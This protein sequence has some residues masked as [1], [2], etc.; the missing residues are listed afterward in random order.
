MELT[1]KKLEKG[2]EP[3]DLIS[4]CTE[5]DKFVSNPPLEC[6]G[7][8]AVLSAVVWNM[9]QRFVDFVNIGDSRIYKLTA[10]DEL[11]QISTDELK[12]VIMRKPNGKPE[13]TNGSAIVRAGLT[14]AFGVG[15][16]Q[17]NPQ[18]CEF[19]PGDTLFLA[20][21]GFYDCHSSFENDLR[22]IAH[23]LD[24]SEPTAKIFKF[25]QN[26]Q[27]DDA[28]LL[29]LRN[30]TFDTAAQNLTE[31]N[32]SELKGK[33]PKFRLCEIMN[34]RLEAEILQKN[35]NAALATLA[36][37]E[38]EHLLP[39]KTMLDALLQTMKTNNFTDGAVFGGIVRL[40]KET[41]K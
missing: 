11:H 15:T 4:I 27:N 37:M 31:S 34:E 24:L 26:Y 17:I 29:I 22:T 5:T 13:L 41:M 8:M 32:Y 18:H 2:F 28:T 19:L 35:K 20:S 33:L 9:Q 10:N 36:I 40:I 38:T 30:H 6:K 39:T 25:Y 12:A 7:M 3:T 23:A 16:V 21:D 1:G 14:N